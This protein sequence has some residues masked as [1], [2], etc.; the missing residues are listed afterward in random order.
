M[1]YD[2]LETDYRFKKRFYSRGK[3]KGTEVKRLNLCAFVICLTARG[4]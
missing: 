3:Q 4:Y 2:F 1:P